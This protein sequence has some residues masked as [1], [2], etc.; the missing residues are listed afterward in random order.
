MRVVRV[1]GPR[2]ADCAFG[3][4]GAQTGGLGFGPAV[5]PMRWSCAGGNFAGVTVL[6]ALDYSPRRCIYAPPAGP[7][8]MLR[9]VFAGVRFGKLLH[10]HHGL[11]VEAERNKNGAPV[12]LTFRIEEPSPEAAG[13]VTSTVLGRV[14]HR[15]GQ[16][17]S[18]FE[19][20]TS[21]ADGK[22]ADL[23]AEVTA[24]NGNRRNYCF[25]ADTR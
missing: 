21:E 16:G 4:Y 17:W 9:L 25:E 18:N 20:D 13:A 10:G 23:V 1:D 19:L 11:Y 7:G 6:P 15:D 3:R 5:P 24:P 22:S 8:S 14:V 12:T 2:E